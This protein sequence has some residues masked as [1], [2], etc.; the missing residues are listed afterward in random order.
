MRRLPAVKVI[1]NFVWALEI[2]QIYVRAFGNFD[3]WQFH[4]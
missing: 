4:I 2:L 1:W 3:F